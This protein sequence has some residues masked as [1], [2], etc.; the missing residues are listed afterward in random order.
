MWVYLISC[1]LISFTIHYH[2]QKQIL[3][4]NYYLVVRPFFHQVSYQLS[5]VLSMLSCRPYKHR[6]CNFS[7]AHFPNHCQWSQPLTY[8]NHCLHCWSL[9]NLNDRILNVGVMHFNYNINR[10]ESRFKL[11]GLLTTTLNI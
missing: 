6:A 8:Q 2:T 5:C 7:V 1:F 9:C 11:S 4:S 10:H 3:V